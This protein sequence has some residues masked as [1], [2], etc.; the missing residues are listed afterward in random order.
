MTPE[1]RFIV[2]E[3]DPDEK[4]RRIWGLRDQVT[5]RL[6]EAGDEVN[7]FFTPFSAA[8]HRLTYHYL[9]ERAEDTDG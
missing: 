5:G 4:G 1:K 8:D 2:E 3:L 7:V 9:A 6:V